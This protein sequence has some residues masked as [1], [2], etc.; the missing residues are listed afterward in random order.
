MLSPEHTE[1][2]KNDPSWTALE[3]HITSCISALDS[4]TGIADGD[5]HDKAAR[6]RKEAV[7]ILHAILEP[8]AYNPKPLQDKRAEAL[9]KLGM[10]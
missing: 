1:K 6:G 2:L 8:F 3:E 4:C 9:R 5:D 10:L 7:K